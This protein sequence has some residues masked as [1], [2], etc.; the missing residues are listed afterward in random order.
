MMTSTKGFL[1]FQ[2]AA[3]LYPVQITPTILHIPSMVELTD[4]MVTA[5][6]VA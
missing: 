2:A 1:Y 4:H 3:Q 6:A 5:L